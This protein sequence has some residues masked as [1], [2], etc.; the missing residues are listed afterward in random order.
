M[1]NKL[2]TGT[3]FVILLLSV[4]VPLTLS[5]TPALSYTIED[6]FSKVLNG[7]V[8]FSS[9]SSI[10]L[11]EIRQSVGVTPA[12]IKFND[13][14]FQ[15]TSTQHINITLLELISYASTA[16]FGDTITKFRVN[17]PVG[18]TVTFKIGGLSGNTVYS[19]QVDSN[20]PV[21]EPSNMYGYITFEHSSWSTHTFTITEGKDKTRKSLDIT[22]DD[23]I[24]GGMLGSRM[25]Y[26]PGTS[27]DENTT[28]N[29]VSTYNDTSWLILYGEHSIDSILIYGISEDFRFIQA[30]YDGDRTSFMI[31][32][33]DYDAWYGYVV[34]PNPGYF[35]KNDW[36]FNLLN[37]VNQV[38]IDGESL[39]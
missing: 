28:I 21:G 36:W 10:V 30:S 27:V 14:E 29:L 32:T 1:K 16:R 18:N 19:V 20:A 15:V 26:I 34:V 7:N 8:W 22:E 11:R 38:F 31:E 24:K 2:F 33:D 3:I 5:I 9:E 37:N 25:F 39:S 23:M 13:V 17:S 35:A 12:Y 4:F 6:G